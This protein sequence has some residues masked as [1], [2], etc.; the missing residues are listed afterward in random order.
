MNRRLR[1]RR[2]DNPPWLPSEDGQA[3]GPAPTDAATN[4]PQ[5]RLFREEATPYNGRRKGPS[6]SPRC[7]GASGPAA[8]PRIGESS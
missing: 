7:R 5:T 3:Q 2:R 6:Q 8:W 4:A 1:R